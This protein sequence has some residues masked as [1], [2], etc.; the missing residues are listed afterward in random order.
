MITGPRSSATCRGVIALVLAAVLAGCAGVSDDTGLG[1]MVVSGKYR[2]YTCSD[3]AVSMKVARA[4]EQEL[5]QLMARSAQGPGG[6][7]VNVIA[8]RTE[9]LQ[10][11][12]DQKLLAE[13]AGNK[14]CT[15]QSQWASER[16]VF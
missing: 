10:A 8:Y 1:M 2:E 7:F 3:L 14:N 11:R 15:S 9:Y 5:A 13:A 6:E 12:V 16:S 4:R